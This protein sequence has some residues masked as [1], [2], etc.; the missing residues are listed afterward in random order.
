MMNARRIMNDIIQTAVP[1]LLGIVMIKV[2]AWLALLLDMPALSIAGT[3]GGVTLCGMGPARILRRLLFPGVDLKQVFHEAMASKDGPGRVFQGVC[4]VIAALIIAL[5]G[6]AARAAELPAKAHQYIPVLLAEQRAHWPSMPLPS[7]LAAQV[8]QESC[9]SL[10]HSR[11]WDP[12]SQLKT[13]REQGVGFGQIT[14]TWR[15]DG[16]PRFD[17]LAELRAQY[18]RQLAGWAWDSATLYDPAYQLR[19]MILMDRRNWDMVLGTASADDRLRMTL[20]AYNGGLRGLASDRAMCAGTAGCDQARWSLHVERTCTKSQTAAPGYRL[21]WCEI[22]REY[23]HNIVNVR[24]PK[25]IA[26]MGA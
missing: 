1:L 14:R 17:S 9:I 3:L 21:S 20:A 12:R 8:E 23:P 2:G 16:S 26:H 25:Y 22:N 19:A 13:S 4:M 6:G 11:C 18:P 15:A 5:S 7:A 10:K 24:R